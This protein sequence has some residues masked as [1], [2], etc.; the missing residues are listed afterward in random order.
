[1]IKRSTKATALLLAAASIISTVPTM[2]ASRLGTKEG[3]IENAIAFSEGK[4]L[5]QGYRTDDD[6]NGLYYNSGDKDK[7]LDDADEIIAKFNNKY[8]LV[9]DSGDEYVV[10]MSTGKITDEDTLDDLRATAKIKLENKLDDTDRYGEDIDFEVAGTTFEEVS[11]NKFEDLWYRYEVASTSS[12]A[13]GSSFDKF[14]YTTSSGKYI[15][16]SYDLN[17]YAYY[18]STTG[19]AANGKTYKIED[20][21]DSVDITAD[22]SRKADPNFKSAEAGKKDQ[23]KITNLKFL[24]Y[25]GQDSKYIYSLIQVNVENSVDVKTNKVNNEARYYVQKVSKEQGDKED[26]AC[27]PKST[28]MFE[29]TNAIGDSD[30][31]D[32]HKTLLD[33][34]VNGEEERIETTIIDGNLYVVYGDDDTV[35]VEKITLKTSHKVDRYYMNSNNEAK[36]KDGKVGVRV[37]IKSD[38][39]DEDMSDWSIDVNGNVWAIYKGK[40]MKSTKAG[41]FETVYTCDRSLDKLDVYDEN[42]LIAWEEDGDVY[43][44]VTEGSDAAKDEAEDIIGDQ[45]KED[46]TVK[47]G[48][49]KNADGTWVLY[50]AAG[51]QVKGWANVGGTWYYMDKSTG[52]M[53]T[54]WLNDNG[55]WYYLQ[56]SGA[57]KTGWLNDRGTWYYLQSSGAMKTG[58]LN[59]RGTWYYLQ[60]SG[61][62][63]TGWL[64]D[65]GTWYYLQSNGAMVANTT[66]DGYRLGANGAWIR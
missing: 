6:D 52:I 46:T 37:A 58:W 27:K 51:S 26:K 14:G 19:S 55:T 4:Y 11:D 10:D 36:L 30:A 33:R 13:N 57:M 65:N 43:T 5:Y 1:M 38:D 12:V 7:M 50:D 56:S 3:T 29:V 17:L 31:A 44:T 66:I 24:K 25:L 9:E 63:K 15:D 21:T 22:E 61:A 23:L 16:C 20:I 32:A 8:V 2:A 47:T 53:K 39:T 64:N 45:D 34:L 49:E 60:S 42:N 28:E 54:G 62:M 40:I 41:D 18:N 59:D 35:N 48:W